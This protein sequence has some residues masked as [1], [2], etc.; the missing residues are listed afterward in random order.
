MLVGCVQDKPYGTVSILIPIPLLALVQ[1][2]LGLLSTDT[3][4]ESWIFSL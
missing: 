1:G 4:W 3:F 2:M